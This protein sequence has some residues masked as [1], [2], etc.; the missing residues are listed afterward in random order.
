MKNIDLAG[1]S[2][3]DLIASVKTTKQE[4]IYFLLSIGLA[5][6]ALL[7]SYFVGGAA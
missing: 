6:A 7:T 2:R 5:L 3:K 1:Q 4:N